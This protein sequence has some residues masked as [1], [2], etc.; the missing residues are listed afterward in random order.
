MSANV[1][2]AR[3]VHHARVIAVAL[4]EDDAI[5]ENGCSW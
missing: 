1:M 2:L 4:K 3:N 5:A